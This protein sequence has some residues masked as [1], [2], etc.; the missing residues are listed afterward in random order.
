MHGV[1]VRPEARG[2]AHGLHTHILNTSAK[3]R[4][5]LTP[6]PASSDGLYG[7]AAGSCAWRYVLA[8]G[9][10]Q[11]NILLVGAG[12][13]GQAYGRHLQLGGATISFLVREQYAEACRAGL[14]L[15]PLN[16]PK[17][18]RWQPVPL[19]R[20]GV[21]TGLE[22]VAAHT[23]EQVWLC[24]SSTALQGPW[25]AAFLEA[26]GT[27]TLVFLQPGL[28]DRDALLEH[29]PTERLVQGLITLLSYHAPLPGEHVPQPGVAYFF[30]PLS[31][32]PFTGPRARTQ[33]VVDALR[34][35]GCRAKMSPHV[36]TQAALG[37][38]V[39]MPHVV[40]LETAGWSLQALRKSPLLT[41]ASRAS[42][43][44]MMIAATYNGFPPPA[45][46][47][48]VHPMVTQLVL[49]LAPHVLPFNL[50][51]YLRY[52]FTKVSAQTRAA[53]AIYMELG[54][55]LGLSSLSLERLL[56]GKV[57]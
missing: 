57:G 1:L 7:R 55:A 18:T 36:R 5:P 21:L 20:F 25:L 41:L 30:P 23:W 35:G 6:E 50:E 9:A 37:S 34:A 39:L 2:N 10:Q 45:A 40:A 22:E 3:P 53:M 33:A 47:H 44:A 52:H 51:A 13:V 17:A 46:R 31:A 19:E 32:T 54:A 8:R 15:Y 29:W 27:A 28:R 12:A 16:R 42:H 11:M 43:E 24:I 48:M 4:G 14:V 56:R 49:G 38:A 26:L